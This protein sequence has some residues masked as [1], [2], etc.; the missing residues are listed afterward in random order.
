MSQQQEIDERLSAMESRLSGIERRQDRSEAVINHLSDEIGKTRR[1][2]KMVRKSVLLMRRDL[3]G[4]ITWP[5]ILTV[6]QAATTIITLYS[7]WRH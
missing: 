3:S 6:A 4:V 7:F 2:I 5:K 1:A